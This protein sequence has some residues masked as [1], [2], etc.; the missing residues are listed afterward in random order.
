M[1]LL[2]LSGLLSDSNS[3]VEDAMNANV[4]RSPKSSFT[5]H[6][7]QNSIKVSWQR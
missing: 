1:S 7:R 6:V 5:F 4:E 2:K 3:L